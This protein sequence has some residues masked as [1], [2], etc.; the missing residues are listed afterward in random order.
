MISSLW[1][2]G[3]AALVERETVYH[4][5]HDHRSP[6]HRHLEPDLEARQDLP[7]RVVITRMQVAEGGRR[8]RGRTAKRGPEGVII[9][10]VGPVEHQPG[11]LVGIP[12]DP[13]CEAPGAILCGLP[14]ARYFGEITVKEI[15]GIVRPKGELLIP[16][17]EFPGPWS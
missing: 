3:R 9:P 2:G 16:E 5:G 12:A 8:A 14:T 15:H 11:P 6:W 1:E 17:A 13:Q 7:G 4:C 10:I